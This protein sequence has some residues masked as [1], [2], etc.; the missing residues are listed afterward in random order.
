MGVAGRHRRD[1]RASSNYYAAESPDGTA[2]D[3]SRPAPGDDRAQHQARLD[4]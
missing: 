3:L 4:G 2:T 1:S